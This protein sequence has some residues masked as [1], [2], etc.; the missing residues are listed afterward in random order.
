[1]NKEKRPY[2][3]PAELSGSLDNPIRKI[4]HKPEKILSGYIREGMTVL[5]L[6]CGPGYFTIEMA[7][8]VGDCGKVIA[9]D[10]QQ[11]MLDKLRKKIS[12]T[13]SER[14]IEL[15]KCAEDTLGIS[16]KVDFVLASWMVHEVPDQDR[17]FRE[18]KSILSPEGKILIIEPK[19]HVS[20][21]SFNSMINLAE[22][23]GF[24]I[25]ER[26]KVTISRSILMAINLSQ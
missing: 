16:Q 22:N 21:R 13:P 9:A 3:C 11:G 17:L 1:M 20:L 23:N 15:H 26:P 7:R 24:I 12:G 4:F 2:V 5:D 19:I 6:G 18:L 8:R 25:I 10:L 14:I